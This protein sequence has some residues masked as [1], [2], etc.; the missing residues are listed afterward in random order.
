M[1]VCVIGA[2]AMGTALALNFDRVG[3]QTHVLATA[4]DQPLYDSLEGDRTHPTLGH[5]I[6]ESIE[7]VPHERWSEVLPGTEIVVLAVA[8]VGIRPVIRD[9][10]GDIEG[11]ILA[12]A[13]KG[14]DPDTAEP[15]S[16]VLAHEAPANPVV[17]LVGPSLAGELASGIPTGMVC[18]SLDASAANTVAA[19]LSGSSVMAYTSTDVKGV[20]VGA[21]L[22]NVL[23]IAI[24]MCDG[25]AEA[26]GRP[27]TNT[28]AALFSR[29]LIEM[30][31]LAVAMGGREQTVLGLA[32]AGDLFV[33]VLGGRNGRFG[34][35]VGTGLAP[36]EA[37]ATMG[38]TVEGFDNT[39]EAVLLA[40]RHGLDLPV[41]RMV[42]SVLYGGIDPE[43]AIKALIRS[44]VE[45]EF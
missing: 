41:V 14:W 43:K 30:G 6:P 37:F 23:A 1:K 32:G 10:V 12:V 13:T 28:K 18:A 40:D 31:R 4:L 22:K 42:S 25:I 11:A 26:K 3:G 2:G 39:K 24:G 34:R 45:P 7:L 38:T 8:S 27:M 5:W 33:T 29:G 21:A 9:I 20:E 15:L 36:D 44:E 35:L 19:S 16:E 17:I